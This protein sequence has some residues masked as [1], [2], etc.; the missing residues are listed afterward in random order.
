MVNVSNLRYS[1]S[2]G[3]ITGGVISVDP[4]YARE[5]LQIELD[6]Y[7]C[8]IGRV[9]SNGTLGIGV[10]RPFYLSSPQYV[11]VRIWNG[12]DLGSIYLG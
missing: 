8:D 1:E 4:I 11:N 10:E 7:W 12:P 5:L 2:K 3:A 6:G 9:M